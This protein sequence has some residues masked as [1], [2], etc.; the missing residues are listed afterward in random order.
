MHFLSMETQNNVTE[1]ILLGL[2]N[3]PQIK[4]QIFFFLLFLVIYLIT[5]TGNI[6]IMV[7]IR[8]DSRLHTPMYFFLFH[9]S[10]VDIC[11]SSVTVPNM[12]VNF[13]AEH[14]TISVHGCIVQLFFFLLSACSEIFILSAMAYDRYAAICDPLRY[15]QIMSKTICIQLVSGA[16][17]IGF[18]Y[19]LLHTVLAL[20]LHFCGSNHIAHFSCE[21]P[22]LLQLSCTKTSTNQVV[23]L[24]SATIVGSSSFFLTVV[25]YIHIISTILKIRSAEGR[26]KA[27][28]TC[29]SHLIVIGLFYLTGFF[30]YT[31]T[32]SVSSAVLDEMISI[33]YSIIT[34]MLNPIIYSFKNKEV[35]TAVWK[36]LG[37]FRFPKYC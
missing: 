31:K 7:V 1:F 19:A 4:M 6:V 34:P 25:S 20:R 29:S 11:Y 9:L 13:L 5:L 12:L 30:R 22:P 27:F 28:S 14:K 17:T 36:I 32:S 26:H 21:L 18:F 10:F 2:S 16:W 23:F 35:K 24:T 37:K 33:Q 3:D 15:M 8:A